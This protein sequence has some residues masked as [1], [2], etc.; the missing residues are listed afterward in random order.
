MNNNDLPILSGDMGTLAMRNG[1]G[2]DALR[3]AI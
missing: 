3:I 2:R 1:D